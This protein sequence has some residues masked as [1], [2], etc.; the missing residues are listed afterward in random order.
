MNPKPF[1]PSLPACKARWHDR[2]PARA[3]LSSRRHANG[4]RSAFLRFFLFVLDR[5]TTKMNH[6]SQFAVKRTKTG[7]AHVRGRDT[8]ATTRWPSPRRLLNVGL[9]T[10]Q[11]RSS[12]PVPYAF[13]INAVGWLSSDQSAAILAFAERF[14]PSRTATSGVIAGTT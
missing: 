12:L 3:N 2:R 6:D 5:W 7:D 4:V 13:Q 8:K 9:A 11:Q 1:M 14:A 10:W